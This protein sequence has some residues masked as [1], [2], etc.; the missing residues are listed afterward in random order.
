MADTARWPRVLV[1]TD[2]AR[3]LRRVGA[4][5]EAWSSLLE[6]QIEGAL[7]GGADLV[8][9]REPD[10]PAGE[11]AQFLRVLF[12]RVGASAGRVVVNDRV[13]VAWVT[14]AAG[15]HLTE[16]SLS[17]EETQS[18]QP[19][20]RRWIIGRSVHQPAGAAAAVGASYLLAGT[21]LPSESKTGAPYLLGWA[22]LAEIVRAADKTPVVAIGGLGPADVRAA[23]GAGAAGV[24]GIGCFLPEGGAEVA[25]SVCQR[26]I[27]MRK[28][29]DTTGG[30][31]YTRSAG[32]RE[33]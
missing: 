31:T 16:R 26:V 17:V 22:G 12:A 8:Q 5:A 25:G 19:V 23:I 11:L 2:R 21:V 30:D 3:L 29:F 24:A 14:G 18:L 20:G 13:D 32:G 33:Q 1:V 28:E 9:V 4:P 6:A 15:V 10:L 7:A 27:A